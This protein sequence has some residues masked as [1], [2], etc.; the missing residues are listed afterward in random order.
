MNTSTKRRVSVLIASKFKA[1]F[2][3]AYSLT[4][5]GASRIS[6]LAFARVKVFVVRSPTVL[7]PI[8]LPILA[9]KDEYEGKL[10]RR[11]DTAS[12][13]SAVLA[14][15]ISPAVNLSQ[16]KVVFH[17]NVSQNPPS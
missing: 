2:E 16:Y 11:A 10:C 12:L 15:N 9:R 1:M 17:M 13:L 3:A 4:N 7:V 8:L 14:M 5:A 6:Q